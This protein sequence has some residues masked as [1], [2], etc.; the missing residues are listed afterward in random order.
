MRVHATLTIR[1]VNDDAKSEDEVRSMLDYAAEHID[2]CHSYRATVD[3]M[4]YTVETREE[5]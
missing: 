3:A 5:K 2:L 1:V 4:E